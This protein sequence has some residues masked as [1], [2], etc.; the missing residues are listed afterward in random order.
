M[1]GMS[2]GLRKGWS[3]VYGTYY[4][5]CPSDGGGL[6]GLSGLSLKKEGGETHVVGAFSGGASARISERER[7]ERPDRP[8]L[9]YCPPTGSHLCQVVSEAARRNGSRQME[10]A[11]RNDFHSHT[12]TWR[13]ACHSFQYGYTWQPTA[14]TWH[15]T[16]S[17]QV[18]SEAA[19]GGGRASKSILTRWAQCGIM[20]P[21]F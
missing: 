8:N 1:C 7:P 3:V 11:R 14:S 13:V 5:R 20:T 4:K 10:A 18:V 6:S 17:S 9:L 16:A 21:S 12:S 19:M 15:I 2:V